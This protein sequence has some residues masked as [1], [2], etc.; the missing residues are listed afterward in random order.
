MNNSGS[1]VHLHDANLAKG[2]SGGMVSEADLMMGVEDDY[3]S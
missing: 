2:I 1:T 3:C